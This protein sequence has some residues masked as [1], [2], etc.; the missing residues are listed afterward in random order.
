[1]Q[2][3]TSAAWESTRVQLEDQL[4][5]RTQELQ[6]IART[7][8]EVQTALDAARA[9]LRLAADLH[10][11]DTR[12]LEE[13]RQ[14]TEQ[15]AR[16][17]SAVEQERQRLQTSLH[18]M[19]QEHTRLIAA[20]QTLET[21]LNEAMGR[22]REFGEEATA[23]RTKLESDTAPGA[24]LAA[25]ERRRQSRRVEEVGK[26]GMAMAPEIEALVSAVDRA[27]E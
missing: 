21:Q 25:E 19:S 5:K 15:S 26:L 27:A 22:V 23:L 8:A 3:S 18:Q 4:R 10:A 24:R 20:R 2:S 13:L 9:E 14:Q 1:T 12:A 11:S 7:R 16:T 6:T 17:V